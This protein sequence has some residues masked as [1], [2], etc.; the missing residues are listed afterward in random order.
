MQVFLS[1]HRRYCSFIVIFSF[2]LALLKENINLFDFKLVFTPQSQVCEDVLL[3]VVG[4]KPQMGW[5]LR[6]A[7][8]SLVPEQSLW[9]SLRSLSGDDE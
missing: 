1:L 3:D 8:R 9:Y 4:L 5:Y 6:V 2:V 7:R